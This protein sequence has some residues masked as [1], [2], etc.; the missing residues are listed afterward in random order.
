MKDIT[1]KVV[2]IGGSAGVVV[3]KKALLIADIEIGEEVLVNA[4]KDKIIIIKKGKK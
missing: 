4:T 3:G 1:K 2:K